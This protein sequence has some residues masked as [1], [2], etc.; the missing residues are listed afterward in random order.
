M[1]TAVV[2]A[3]LQVETVSDLLERLGDIPASRVLLKPTPGTATVQDVIDIHDQADRLCELV[4]GTLVEKAMGYRESALAAAI[5]AALR[6]FVMPK[7]L[8]PVT[9]AD[10]MLRLFPNLVRGPDAAFIPWKRIPGGRMPS[11]AIPLLAPSLAV[12]VLSKSNTPKEMERKRREYFKAGVELVWIVEPVTRIVDV[13]TSPSRFTTLHEND[14]LVGGD[15]LPGF[16][17]SLKELFAELDQVGPQ[18]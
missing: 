12:E 13:Y 18:A 3:P 2:D 10:G 6:A 4:D 8:G 14:T 9:G 11:E 7:N 16:T 17:L 15:V 1:T 5:C